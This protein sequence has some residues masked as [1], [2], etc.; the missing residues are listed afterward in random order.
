[1]IFMP[2][3]GLFKLS[4]VINLKGFITNIYVVWLCIKRK[5]IF[6]NATYVSLVNVN[7]VITGPNIIMSIKINLEVKCVT[8][9]G[10][11]KS[12]F[13]IAV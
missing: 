6:P 10:Q 13:P 9:Y 8:R 1:M 2:L 7:D 11:N 4:N 12:L 3:T 5:F